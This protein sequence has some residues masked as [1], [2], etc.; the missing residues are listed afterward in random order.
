MCGGAIMRFE[1]LYPVMSWAQHQASWP[2]REQ[3]RFVRVGE[4]TWHVQVMGQGPALLL[5]HGTGAGSFSW[6]DLMP[7]LAQHFRVYAPDLPGHVF[8]GRGVAS[9]LSLRGMSEALL[10]LTQAL[11]L[12]PKAIA[13]HSAGAAIAADMVLR[14]P[15]LRDT[16]LIGLNPAWLPLPG[17]ASWLFGPAAKL[18]AL[19]PASAWL[20]AKWAARPGVVA[21]ALA[22]TGSR[23]EA[24]AL[25]CYE[26]VFAHAGHVH[27]VLGMMAAWDMAALAESLP[28]IQNPVLILV[29]EHDQTVPVDLARQ[30][31]AVLPAA[32]LQ[33]QR[34]LGHLAHEER[35]QEAAEALLQ[36]A[37]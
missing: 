8:T 35:P 33:C 3:S 2:Q 23:L 6:R 22:Q 19:N 10:A 1:R 13:G 31:L 16:A 29:G 20:T 27:S 9:A 17:L 15:R 12:T 28:R 34:G 7:R 4:G 21:K 24:P 14:D 32:R 36:F 18:A 5:L 25:R 30:A 37:A 26:T 11:Q